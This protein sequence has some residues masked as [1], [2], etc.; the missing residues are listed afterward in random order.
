VN[1]HLGAHWPTD[2]MGGYAWGL[3]LLLPALWVAG[4]EIRRAG[5]AVSGPE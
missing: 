4:L 5:E 3:V 1:V 2:V